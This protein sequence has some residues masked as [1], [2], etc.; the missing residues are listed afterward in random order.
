LVVEDEANVRKLV[1]VNLSSRGYTV[2]EAPDAQRALEQLRSQTVDLLVL[3][4]KLP[5]INGWTLLQQ[6]AADSKLE[7]ESPVLVM[8]A[9]IMDAHLDMDQY[10]MVVDVLIKPFSVA[11]LVAAVERALSYRM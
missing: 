8:T 10:P 2:T 7:F 6:V 11:M 9:S 3:D 1:T 4:I 5:D